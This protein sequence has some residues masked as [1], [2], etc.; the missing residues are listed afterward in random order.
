MFSI[1]LGLSK[2]RLIFFK[3]LQTTNQCNI[4]ILLVVA[5]LFVGGDQQFRIGNLDLELSTHRFCF[6]MRSDIQYPSTIYVDT[7]N[8]SLG[9]GLTQI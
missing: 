9:L 4:V 2:F 7:T 6:D 8:P 3:G 1:L 5:I